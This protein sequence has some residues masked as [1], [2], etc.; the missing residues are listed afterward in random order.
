MSLKY[1][2]L[3]GRP[4]TGI[5]RDDCLKL[6]RDFY[7]DNFQ[8]SIRDYARPHDWSSDK[9]DLM[10]LCYEREG[11]DLI[12]DWKIKDLRPA[13]VLCV[14]IG[15]A[16]PNHFSIY[17]GDNKIVH[18]LYGQLSREEPFRDFWRNH[19]GFVLRHPDVPDLRP[20]YPDV[21]LMELLRARNS[22]PA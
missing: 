22:P 21:D 9:L 5:G 2:H 8:I 19:T 1:E 12:T 11:F 14:S 3:L 4:F 13:D 15:E 6:F 16:N 20:T 7:R 10:R 18:H 17:V